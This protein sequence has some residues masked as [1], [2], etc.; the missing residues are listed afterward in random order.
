MSSEA[1]SN[2]SE[3]SKSSFSTKPPFWY[4]VLATAVLI[5]IV[6]LIATQPQPEAIDYLAGNALP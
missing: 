1:D 2:I 6:A 3:L 5:T 4:A